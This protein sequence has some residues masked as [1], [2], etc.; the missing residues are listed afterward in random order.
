MNIKKRPDVILSTI[1]LSVLMASLLHNDGNNGNDGN[2]G[3]DAT[4]NICRSNNTD[5]ATASP[6][7]TAINNIRE[8]PLGRVIN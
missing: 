6:E 5:N 2:D 7:I 4:H 1:V 3:N 8:F